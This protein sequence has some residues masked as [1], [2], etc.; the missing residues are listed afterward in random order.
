MRDD[1]FMKWVR[2]LPKAA[3]SSAVGAATRLPAPAPLHHFAMRLF[4]R[5]YGVDL[6]EAEHALE[7]YGTF[8]EF[9]S[10]GLKPGLREVAQGDK[11]LVSPV[12]GVVSQVGTLDHGRLVQAKNIDYSAAQL[13]ADA[14]AAARFDNGGAFITL[15]LSPRDYHRIHAPLPGRI[16]GYRYIPGQFWPV[17]PAS[18]GSV[19]GLFSL[20]ERLVTYLETP[21]GHMAVVKVGATCVA[22]IRASYD[23]VLTHA[24]REANARRYDLPIPLK[25]GQELGRFEMGSTVILLCEPG[26]VRWDDALRPEVAVRMGQRLGDVS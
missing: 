5:R 3:L 7:G 16:L 21:A 15:Y 10:R 26:H 14:E 9:F 6:G 13:L 2:L 25:K 22:R 12:D 20:N 24:G 11:V 17:N 23:D 1:L 8:A 4:A 18:V 19:P